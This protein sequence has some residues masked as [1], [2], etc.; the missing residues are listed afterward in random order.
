MRP[1]SPYLKVPPLAHSTTSPMA[2]FLVVATSR[3]AVRNSLRSWL[4]PEHPADPLPLLLAEG[5]AA[6]SVGGLPDPFPR[7]SVSHF[8]RAGRLQLHRRNKM[9]IPVKCYSCFLETNEEARL[10]SRMAG[11]MSHP[12]PVSPRSYTRRGYPRDARR[13]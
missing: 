6:P 8:F 12:G 11:Q 9:V 5:E 13:T 3:A 2:C 1:I 7:C 4:N 10:L